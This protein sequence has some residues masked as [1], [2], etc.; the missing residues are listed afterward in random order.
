MQ[1]EA[2]RFKE[3][4][5]FCKTTSTEK[6]HAIPDTEDEIG[7]LTADIAEYSEEIETLS[8]QIAGHEADIAAWT[9]ELE[10]ATYSR[11]K[12]HADFEVEHTDYTES[13][14]SV[15]RAVETIKAGAHDVA[16]L[17]RQDSLRRLSTLAKAPA[18]TRR[19]IESF[20]Q[21]KGPYDSYFLELSAG[22]PEAK[23][24]EEHSG[25]VLTMVEEM[26]EKMEN[27]REEIEK[28]E[29]NAKHA[30]D[31][32]AQDLNDQIETNKEA[33]E[34]K[35]SQKGEAGENKAQ[36]ESDLA[37]AKATLAEDQKFLADL[38][39]E[40]EQKTIDFDKRQEVRQRGRHAVPP[41]PRAEAGDRPRAA[42]RRRLRRRR[43]DHA[44][45]R[46]RVPQGPR[47]EGQQQAPLPPGRARRGGPLQEGG[48]DDQGHDHEA[49]G[50]GRGRG[51]GE[52]LLRQ[53]DDLEP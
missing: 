17:Q 15:E 37:T 18:K 10:E 51:R 20:L 14:D 36:A 11:E 48:Q 53:G 6:S 46:R 40:C 1:D 38:T 8:K 47:R 29:M 52:G 25:G 5:A 19:A 49:H 2:E 7:D 45:E 43:Q 42:A 27:K 41:E 50:G 31:M 39:A 21:T 23:A 35:A 28:V 3:Y 32:M 24:Y 34:K 4:K 13:I 44:A 22:A 12:E 26:G 33:V 30:Y 9:T 16:M